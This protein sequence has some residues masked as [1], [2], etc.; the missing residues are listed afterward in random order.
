MLFF[1]SSTVR[2]DSDTRT[3]AVI[4]YIPHLW[5][6]YRDEQ[7]GKAIRKKAVRADLAE[8]VFSAAWYDSRPGKYIC[9][10]IG[11]YIYK[12]I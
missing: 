4:E 3:I 2:F 9:K 5:C 11:K 10:Q 12:H 7:R 8:S 6:K 1:Y